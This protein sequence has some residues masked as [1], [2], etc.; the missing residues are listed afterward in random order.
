MIRPTVSVPRA[1]ASVRSQKPGPQKHICLKDIVKAS[2]RYFLLN[3][4]DSL[5]GSSVKIGTIQRRLA[6]PLRKDDTQNREA[7]HIFCPGPCYHYHSTII[8]PNIY[9]FCFA[10]K[11]HTVSAEVSRLN[12]FLE[13][14][15][16]QNT[17]VRSSGQVGRWVVCCLWCSQPNLT[18]DLRLEFRSDPN[19][20]NFEASYSDTT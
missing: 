13:G 20:K 19:I 11:L 6:W 5:R 2:I 8:R 1:R 16:R 14:H 10:G 15:I 7:F 4:A 17:S 9:V 3:A 18:P 12:I